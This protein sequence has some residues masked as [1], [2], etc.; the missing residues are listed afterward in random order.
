MNAATTLDVAE[1]ILAQLGGPARLSAMIGARNFVGEAS[2]LTFKFSAPAKNK[3]NCVVITLD[4][5]DTYTVRFCRVGRA[6][7]FEVAEKGETSMV[8]APSLRAVIESATG[9]RLSL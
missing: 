4:E 2:S 1:I 9:L 7:L 8:H 6:P 3:A 5:S